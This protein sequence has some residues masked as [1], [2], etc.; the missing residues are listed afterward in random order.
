MCEQ[1]TK[2]LKTYLIIIFVTLFLS[3]QNAQENIENF[4]DVSSLPLE[5]LTEPIIYYT[6]NGKIRVRVSTNKMSRYSGEEDI[7]KLS[8]NVKIE[9]F[10]SGVSDKKSELTC[11]LALINNT[12]DI[13]T[14]NEDVLLMGD[15]K[16]LST[17]QL[18]WDKNK[19]VIYTDSEVIITTQDEV[20]SGVGFES[21]PEFTEYEIKKAK[22]SFILQKD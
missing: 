6:E 11:N 4:I 3:C 5:E 17:E 16:E 21:N 1:E 19:D 12:T 20:I 8:G 10:R 15:Q 7:V 2:S 22:G 13:M 14:A 9:F 18:I